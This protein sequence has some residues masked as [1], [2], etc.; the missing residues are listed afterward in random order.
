MKTNTKK[1]LLI[2]ATVILVFCSIA[3]FA[4]ALNYA[5]VASEPF[6]WVVSL[7]AILGLGFCAYK[8]ISEEFKSLDK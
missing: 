1:Y 7:I 8:T 6:Y 5:Y 2:V 3:M 4:G